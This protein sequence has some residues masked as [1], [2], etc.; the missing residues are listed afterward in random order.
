MIEDIR[1]DFDYIVVDAP[2]VLAKN[3]G[4]VIAAAADLTVLVMEWCSTSRGAARAATQRLVDMRAT[5]LSF[6]VTKVDEKQ[7]FYFRPEDR[8]FFFRRSY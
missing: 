7:R 4:S 8:Q 3:E 6:V 5:I 2:S 1:A